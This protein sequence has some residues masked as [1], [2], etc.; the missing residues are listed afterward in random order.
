[1]KHGR[2]TVLLHSMHADQAVLLLQ[3]TFLIIGQKF[4]NIILGVSL[5]NNK[6]IVF[7]SYFGVARKFIESDIVK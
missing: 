2:H 4:A 1:M 5:V 6:L 7:G 3:Q